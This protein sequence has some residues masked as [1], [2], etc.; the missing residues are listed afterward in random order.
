MLRNGIEFRFSSTAIFTV[1]SFLSSHQKAIVD[2]IGEVIDDVEARMMLGTVGLF[3]NDRQFGILDEGELYLC[4]NDEHKSDFVD[5]GT[6]P[7][8]AA[9]V[10]TASYLEVPDG[11]LADEE[12]LATWTE[13]AVTAAG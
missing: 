11:I 4:V 5:A 3:S 13:R 7:Y 9:A 2:R 1:M 8:N 12:A 6:E 10:D